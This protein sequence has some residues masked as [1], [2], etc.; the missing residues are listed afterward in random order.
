MTANSTFPSFPPFLAPHPSLPHAPP[1]Q[2][3][4]PPPPS[5]HAVSPALPP[6]FPP[7]FPSPPPPS[8]PSPSADGFCVSWLRP[9]RGSLLS[10]WWFATVTALPA[11]LFLV[12]LVRRLRAAVAQLRRSHSLVMA[13]YYV[14]LW[15]ATGVNLMRCLVQII[16]LTSPPSPS[17]LSPSP[18]WDTAWLAT[19][20]VLLFME[21]SVVVFLCQGV[22]LSA[23]EALL[24]TAI[25]AGV[26]AG[27]DVAIKSSLVF[28]HHIPLYYHGWAGGSWTKW[29]FWA[30]HHA[31]KSA[32][33]C[34]LV[35]L[36][37]TRW[38]DK[39]PA[40]PP[41]HRYVS[42]LLAYNACDAVACL[43][44]ALNLHVGYCIH[45]LANFAYVA[46]FPPL[47]YATFL[48]DFFKDEDAAVEDA[49]Y[50]EMRDA[51]YFDMEEDLD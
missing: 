40:S 23:S 41:F 8:V 35:M 22:L 14:L 19:S 18:S 16:V 51:G 11:L 4:P 24:R 39:M 32:V 47:L 42:I 9:H 36:P 50:A 28:G 45:G 2:T 37:N 29:G 25:I 21:A 43:T 44:L 10:Y 12:F 33:Y 34:G 5:P 27:G 38:R 31:I 48:A 7:L 1:P 6:L 26:V 15:G 46:L 13:A 49:Y 30:A 17:S 20:F 3:L